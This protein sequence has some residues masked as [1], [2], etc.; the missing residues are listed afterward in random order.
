MEKRQ[1]PEAIKLLERTREQVGGTLWSTRTN[2]LLGWCY[3]HI[4]DADQQL[5]A[6]DRAAKAEPNLAVAVA[7]QGSAL[8]ALGRLNE[9]LQ[10]LQKATQV[11]TGP[12]DTW[13]D[14]NL[15]EPRR[16]LAVPAGAWADLARCLMLRNL[17]LPEGERN[18]GDVNS[19][20]QQAARQQGRSVEVVIL[21]A[22]I[23]AAQKHFDP[24]RTLLEDARAQ[25]PRSVDIECAWP[26][27]CAATEPA[28]AAAATAIEPGRGPGGA[29]QGPRRSW[30]IRVPL[31]QAKLR[32]WGR[33][34]TEASRR[35]VTALGENLQAFSGAQR[36]RLCA[37]WPRRGCV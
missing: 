30:A 7:G 2:L 13:A 23:E 33:T 32:L 5:L 29:R 17:R 27:C 36:A 22:E 11:A 28:P 25:F 37:T 34:A 9:A 4:G 35:E 21:Q 6:Y 19:A 10:L 1:W 20:F 31:R 14:R 24:A 26:I 3:R 18:W 16:S 15:R 8:L 12:T